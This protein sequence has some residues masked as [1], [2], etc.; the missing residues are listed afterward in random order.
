MGPS[1]YKLNLSTLLSCVWTIITLHVVY[2]PPD[3]SP[4]RKSCHPSLKIEMMP[5]S[6]F[7]RYALAKV[8]RNST[9]LVES[10]SFWEF[11]ANP[12]TID[13]HIYFFCRFS[14]RLPSSYRRK[15]VP[16]C[17]TCF[18]T[19]NE[20][21]APR[22]VHSRIKRYTLRPSVGIN[23]RGG[24]G[25]TGKRLTVRTSFS[26]NTRPARTNSW[27]IWTVWDDRGSATAADN[28]WGPRSCP[29]YRPA[30]STA[31]CPATPPCQNP[32]SPAALPPCRSRSGRAR[33]CW[34]WIW[35]SAGHRQVSANLL[36]HK[37]TSLQANR[38]HPV[39]CGS[40]FYLATPYH[41]KK[42]KSLRENYLKEK[43]MS[44][45][46]LYLEW[47]YR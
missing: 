12:D 45:M 25:E 19:S 30:S 29:A 33:S 28:C 7:F 47:K 1:A 35:P 11:L 39:G 18:D 43:K 38:T 15:Y 32:G 27:S 9:K 42:I 26:G 16:T 4:F 36:L 41:H 3:L 46:V 44:M 13:G 8:Q 24:A 14:A 40:E 31:G 22:I 2:L 37:Y 21:A 20:L 5:T 17:A 10:G 6:N 34:S 23:G